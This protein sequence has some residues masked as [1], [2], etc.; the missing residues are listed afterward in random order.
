MGTGLSRNNNAILFVSDQADPIELTQVRGQEELKSL[1]IAWTAAKLK[2]EASDQLKVIEQEGL[3]RTKGGFIT[4]S[5]AAISRV[6]ENHGTDFNGK[7]RPAEITLR[8]GSVIK[9]A[10]FDDVM[11]KLDSGPNYRSEISLGSASL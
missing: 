1:D 5:K 8:N 3:E 6:V 4:L 11:N 9:A 2:D 7:L 10:S